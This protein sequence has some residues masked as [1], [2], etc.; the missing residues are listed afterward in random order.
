MS[1]PL[2][3]R[4]AVTRARLDEAFRLVQTL[5]SDPEA[6]SCF[7][8]YREEIDYN[9]LEL[10]LDALQHLAESSSLPPSAWEAF[11]VAAESMDL[12]ERAARCRSM[13]KYGRQ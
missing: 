12:T 4:W 7:A 10:A 8:R 1:H 13:K 6:E 11:A 5:R 9:E 3:Q 2:E